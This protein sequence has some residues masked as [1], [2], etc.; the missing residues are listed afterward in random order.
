MAFL[1]LGLGCFLTLAG[2]GLVERWQRSALKRQSLS[3]EDLLGGVAVAAG[4]LI[5]LWWVLSFTAALVAAMFESAGRRRA[6]AVTGH[7]SP[8]FMRRLALAILGVQLIGAPLAHADNQPAPAESRNGSVAITAAWTPIETMSGP[9]PPRQPIRDGNPDTARPTAS[10]VQQL[11]GVSGL[12]PQWQPSP[13][14]AAPGPVVS[15]P[16]RAAREHQAGQEL[17]VR[18]GDSLWTIAARHLGPEASDV[19]IAL[20]WPRWFE[21]NRAVI[22]SDPDTLLP[23]QILKAP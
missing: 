3:F 19:D 10:T 21:N 22:G 8:A 4:L 13:P 14:A 17:V 20:E 5:V 23:G 16:P 6:A 15:V 12:Q 9:E 1:I 18:S 7:F 2:T 11:P